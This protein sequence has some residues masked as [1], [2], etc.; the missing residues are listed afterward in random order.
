MS[1]LQH[2]QHEQQQQ[3]LALLDAEEAGTEAAGC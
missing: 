3:E 1:P 2:E